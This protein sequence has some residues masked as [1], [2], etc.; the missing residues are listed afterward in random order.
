M[1]LTIN[2]QPQTYTPTYNEMSYIVE[3]DQTAQSNFRIKVEV[4]I[5]HPL[6]GNGTLVYTGY[7]IPRPDTIE[8]IFD[9]Q[10]IV[11][12]YIKQT[13]IDDFISETYGVVGHGVAGG[14]GAA[15]QGHDIVST[16]VTFTE[17]YGSPRADQATTTV[18]A[19]AFNSS[20][21]YSDFIDYDYTSYPLVL[22]NSTKLF[23]TNMPNNTNIGSSESLQ[24]SW[25]QGDDNGVDVVSEH[26]EIKVYTIASVLQKTVTIVT[27]SVDSLGL[28][29]T[30][31][32]R[33]MLLGTKDIEAS[34]LL[35]G[36]KPVFDTA[37]AYYTVQSIDSDTNPSSELR[38]FTIKPTCDS[39]YR[40]FWLNRLGGIDSFTFEK[41]HINTVEV[42]R[43]RVNRVGSSS[44]E[45][46]R[47]YNVTS[48]D[49]IKLVSDWLNNDESIWLED[50]ITSSEIWIYKN[51]KYQS[52]LI[53]NHNT[54][55]VKT[56][57]QDGTFNLE[58]DVSFA[59]KSNSQRA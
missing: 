27:G 2:Q 17:Q 30:D 24:L 31:F 49:K 42:Q 35:S 37:S 21:K 43:D 58:L 48:T 51:S 5:A 40:V 33:S 44:A 25:L 57:G 32:F 39:P 36:T 45:G 23:L 16:R 22:N 52:I 34:T 8:I 3:S 54:Y 18:S 47:T 12:N 28:D 13:L 55:Q 41:K 26:I 56:Q 19:F 7:F 53:D 46:I 1:A 10:R 50:L 14:V 29:Y 59:Y 11:E 9:A 6:I 20:L 4:G 38:T 15:N